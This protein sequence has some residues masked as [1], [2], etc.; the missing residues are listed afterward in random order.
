MWIGGNGDFGDAGNWQEVGGSLQQVPGL[1]DTALFSGGNYQVNFSDGQRVAEL[2][3]EAGAQVSLAGSGLFTAN[4]AMLDAASLIVSGDST[5]VEIT[6]NVVMSGAAGLTAADGAIVLVGERLD[7]GPEQSTTVTAETG[8]IFVGVTADEYDFDQV[9]APAVLAA[10][11]VKTTTGGGEIV[12]GYIAARDIHVAWRSGAVPI[13]QATGRFATIGIE[14][15]YLEGAR[16]D[17]LLLGLPLTEN[18]EPGFFPQS[19]L[20]DATLSYDVNTGQLRLSVPVNFTG[21]IYPFFPDLSY[22]V[23]F[24]ATG[25]LVAYADIGLPGQ[26]LD[27]TALDNQF[28]FLVD[29]EATFLDFTIMVIAP[30]PIGSLTMQAQETDSLKARFGGKLVAEFTSR[31][32]TQPASIRFLDTSVIDGINHP[33]PFLP[34]PYLTTTGAQV[35]PQG[36][37]SGRGTIVGDVINDGLVQVSAPSGSPAP[38]LVINDNF[39]QT[40]F[41]TLQIDVTPDYH[42]LAAALAVSGIATINHNLQF[43]LQGDFGN[44]TDSFFVVASAN[45]IV[46]TFSDVAGNRAANTYLSLDYLSDDNAVIAIPQQAGLI[47]ETSPS[48]YT[49]EAGKTATFDVR[50]AAPPTAPVTIQIGTSDSSEGTATNSTGGNTLLFT[51][52]NWNQLQTV[53]VTGADDLDADGDISYFVNLHVVSDDLAY[54]GLADVRPPLVNRDN[55]SIQ[56]KQASIQLRVTDQDGNVL[57]EVAVGQTFFLEMWV[58][59]LR[60]EIVGSVLAAYADVIYSAARASVAGPAVFS[61]DYPLDRSLSTATAG[62]LDELGAATSTELGGDEQLLVRVPFIATS[63]GELGFT[64]NA[65]GGAGHGVRLSQLAGSLPPPN[66]DFGNT[67]V[68]VVQGM[69]VA[70]PFIRYVATDVG[71]GLTAY[72][73]FLDDP[74]DSL[75]SY[76]AGLQFN[77]AINQLSGPGTLPVN[78]NQAAATLHGTGGYDRLLDSYFFSPFTEFLVAP[79]IV[80]TASSYAIQAGTGGGSA[81]DLV[82]LAHIVAA[83]DLSFAGVIG[84]SGSTIDVS[85]VLSSSGARSVGLVV[86]T[87]QT[88]LTDESGGS[89]SF[90]VKLTS[91]PIAPVTVQI[92]TTDDSE[93]TATNQTGGNTLVFTPA[94]WDQFQTVI[95]TGADDLE[96]DGDVA[97]LVNLHVISDDL[98]YAGLADVQRSAINQDNDTIEPATTVTLHDAAAEEGDDGQTA[99]NFQVELS[100]LPTA[101]ITVFYRVFADSGD[102]ATADDDFVAETGSITFTPDEATRFK[103]IVAHVNGDPYFETSE[104]FHVEITGIEGAAT[105][106]RALATGTIVNDDA[107][108]VVSIGNATP[109]FEGNSGDTPFEFQVSVSAAIDA[110]VTVFYRIIAGTGN[111]AAT[112]GE[113][114]TAVEDSITFAASGGPQSQTIVALVHGD[115]QAEFTENFRVELTGVSG[116]AQLG[117]S[118]GTGTILNDDAPQLL[119]SRAEA[120][121]GDDGES[122]LVFTVRLSQIS[123]DLITVFYQ[124]GQNPLLGIPEGTATAGEDY[125]ARAGFLT[126]EAGTIEQSFTVRVFGDTDEEDN[127]T[128]YV[129]LYD[130]RHDL[131]GPIRQATII[132]DDDP[133]ANNLPGTAPPIPISNGHGEIDGQIGA[134]P[135]GNGGSGELVDLLISEGGPGALTG[136]WDFATFTLTEQTLVRIEVIAERLPLFGGPASSL[137][138]VLALLKLDGANTQLFATNDDTIG[139]DPVIELLLPVGT[140]AVGVGGAQGTRGPYRLVVDFDSPPVVDR[141]TP[142]STV[143]GSPTV[144]TLFLNDADLDAAT[145]I[146]E[147]FELLIEDPITKALTALD[148]MLG[149]PQYREDLHRILVPIVGSLADGRYVLR[150]RDSILS[151]LGGKLRSETPGPDDFAFEGTFAVDTTPPALLPDT[152]QVAG[153]SSTDAG[154]FYRIAGELDDAV[155]AAAGELVRVELDI[156]DDGEFDDGFATLPL[157]ADGATA[158]SVLAITALPFA[159]GSRDV[160]VRFV[161]ARGNTSDPYT[162][163]IDTS[164]PIVTDVRAAATGPKVLVSFSRD[165]LENIDQAANYTISSGS[166]QSVEMVD[167]RTV[168][169]TLDALPDGVYSLTV[170]TGPSAIF[171]PGQETPQD[172]TTPQLVAQ[173]DA[174]EPLLLDGNYDGTPGDDFTGTFVVD[175][176]APTI[177][178]IKLQDAPGEANATRAVQPTLLVAINDVFPGLPANSPLALSI[179]LDGDGLFNDGSATFTLNQSN[180]AK[181]VELPVNRP[182]PAGSYSANVRLVD[183]AGNAV[184]KSFTFS[185]DRLGP[186]ITSA[187]VNVV[188]DAGGVPTGTVVFELEFSEDLDPASAA[189]LLTYRLLSAGGDG[190]FFDVDA[191]TDQSDAIVSRI[192]QA[193]SQPGGS[194][195]VTITAD[196]TGHP[197]DDYQL[198]V[199]GDLLVDRA[200]NRLVGGDY[201]LPAFQRSAQSR[202]RVETATFASSTINTAGGTVIDLVVLNFSGPDLVAAQVQTLANYTLT[203]PAGPVGLT[204]VSY[205][206]LTNRA[207]LRLSQPVSA[208]G[209]YQLTIRATQG[210]GINNLGG[211]PLLGPG[212]VEEPGDIVVNVAFGEGTFQNLLNDHFPSLV[213]FA[214]QVTLDAANSRKAVSNL[215]FAARL[216]QELQLAGNLTG[217][218]AE[219]AAQVNALLAALIEEQLA[220]VEA[221]KL[222]NQGDFVVLWARDA[223]FLLGD[224]SN[225]NAAGDGKRVG[226][227]VNGLLVQE[228]PGATLLQFD[229]ADGPLMLVILPVDPRADLVGTELVLRNDNQPA[230]PNFLLDLELEGY[231]DSNQAGYLLVSSGQ[232]ARS[233]TYADVPQ[234]TEQQPFVS[235]QFN[236]APDVSGVDP[237]IALINQH[238][239]QI[240][241][242]LFGP[243]GSLTHTLLWGWIDPV[244]YTLGIAQGTLGSQGNQ[245]IDTAAG[246]SIST[247]GATGLLVWSGAPSGLYNLNFSGLGTT[248]RGALNFNDGTNNLYAS[249]QGQLGLGASLQAQVDFRLGTPVATSAIDASGALAAAT[250]ALRVGSA[251]TLGL[252]GS[253]FNPAIGGLLTAGGN[254][255]ASGLLASILQ[256]AGH[257]GRRGQDPFAELLGDLINLRFRISGNLQ[258][259]WLLPQVDRLIDEAS[260]LKANDIV[261]INRIKYAMESIKRQLQSGIITVEK[262]VVEGA[263]DERPRSPSAVNGAP[264][265]SDQPAAGYRASESPAGESLDQSTRVETQPAPAEESTTSAAATVPTGQ[266]GVTATSGEGSSDASR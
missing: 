235:Q 114:F 259:I 160:A 51:V 127:E 61:T 93:G 77:G 118:I 201:R 265:S 144:L 130:L 159:G 168:E 162:L 133:A 96:V 134:G 23:N 25:Q 111:S 41:G 231:S 166:I 83:G 137:D 148:D 175:R 181:T 223:R 217:S 161:D 251:S 52:D 115:Q 36:T 199:D 62:L 171:A 263:A 258:M 32:P 117:Q 17:A 67:S 205:D 174:T 59:D 172:L 8:G 200:G 149:D 92:G 249:V 49:D 33:A 88:L 14:A 39:T 178:S 143:A 229:T 86:D 214:D 56:E 91:A 48:F 155:P 238:V 260:G 208:A 261:G 40:E 140:Y 141:M 186:R 46:G 34:G 80:Q 257:V 108:P 58:D 145:V 76:F 194:A 236:L 256:L 120:T 237:N 65:A 13:D 103:N 131:P 187:T 132:D 233:A 2:K 185:V 163:V 6:T 177:G 60:G 164:L 72:D 79:G 81:L 179:E 139:R 94:N 20:G 183:A 218:S 264:R 28:D 227:N 253:G 209:N 102:A 3:I 101:P 53:I 5:Q 75:R 191:G 109:K 158:F 219:V 73:I 136:D 125:E 97:Y 57:P 192:Y 190:N 142:G 50:L 176:A 7:L 211:F 202:S 90:G 196:L 198:I 152:L 104:T 12:Y 37:L 1:A 54:A 113:D 262:P 230:A 38:T 64:A 224:P 99:I 100:Q 129:G 244:D 203:G 150:V 255:G 252:F 126:F 45:T 188:K 204:S 206:P 242:G 123:D 153:A 105:L 21:N 212:S 146:D 9:L 182:L 234:G 98:G 156:D 22:R 24:E 189:G 226:Q 124:I 78:D 239:Q 19:V 165:D 84:R 121:E 154:L 216:L 173:L 254:L 122:S 207:I 11:A 248:Y 15:G 169:L 170:H 27:F 68:N 135:G 106:S 180:L 107:Q 232:V 71:N 31:T 246:G 213:Q 157:E 167:S 47:V 240:V 87:V 70:A 85:G 116:P 69:T 225:K 222:A 82:Q 63:A 55:D 18:L 30:A 128:F 221:D 110:P 95:V 44:R 42:S 138:A 193:A 220:G 43:N 241:E 197:D 151:E 247:N 89:A 215:D 147:A 243:L 266:E 26:Q 210:E 10:K 66:V 4:V 195:K 250:F 119:M 112:P 184:S 35:L 245:P 29:P 74:S 16:V 228:I